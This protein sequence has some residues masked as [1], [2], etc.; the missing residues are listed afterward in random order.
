MYENPLDAI[1]SQKIARNPRIARAVNTFFAML[2][3]NDAL[4][5]ISRSISDRRRRAAE[6]G[7][8]DRWWPDL[9]RELHGKLIAQINVELANFRPK[10]GYATELVVPLVEETTAILIVS[11]TEAPLPSIKSDL[12]LI[13]DLLQPAFNELCGMIK[14]N[15]HGREK[16]GILASIGRHTFRD[17]FKLG[18]GAE[19]LSRLEAF[20]ANQPRSS[21]EPHITQDKSLMGMPGV[22]VE[23]SRQDAYAECFFEEDAITAEDACESQADNLSYS[24]VDLTNREL[25]FYECETDEKAILLALSLVQQRADARRGSSNRENALHSSY[26]CGICDELREPMFSDDYSESANRIQKPFCKLHL[27][28]RSR[29][30]KSSSENVGWFV[31]TILREAARDAKYRHRF[32]GKYCDGEL[33]T[34]LIHHISNCE[35]CTGRAYHPH[36]LEPDKRYFAELMAFHANVRKVAFKLANSYYNSVAWM[37]DDHVQ[38]GRCVL[39]FLGLYGLETAK[40]VGQYTGLAL[41]RLLYQKV[42]GAEIAARLGISQ[43][44][45]S[46]RRKSMTGSYDFHH[47]RNPDLIWWPFDDIQGD[48]ILRFPVYALGKQWQHSTG[49]YKDLAS[50]EMGATRMHQ[51]SSISSSFPTRSSARR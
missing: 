45:V 48:D 22:I 12:Q 26:F 30:G 23:I 38:D 2:K 49:N 24:M 18:K 19:L 34:E 7:K 15:T 37:I 3:V 11:R 9:N 29:T 4:L 21:P 16:D 5:R 51:R 17:W 13:D 8:R 31:S 10:D 28:A 14:A 40:A 47:A 41:A 32:I 44:A 36:C 1:L 33:L 46:Q 27:D 35:F 50:R 42:N 25:G 20:I 43:S 6:A 39:D